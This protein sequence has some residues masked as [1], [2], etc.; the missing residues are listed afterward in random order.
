MRTSAFTVNFR[1]TSWQ[2]TEHFQNANTGHGNAEYLF[3]SML[4]LSNSKEKRHQRFGA[5][6]AKKTVTILLGY[7]Q[8][9]L[10]NFHTKDNTFITNINDQAL[11]GYADAN[12][13]PL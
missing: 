4:I 1:A 6:S 5:F 8:L 11:L 2:P 9:F 13:L 10:E 12:P 7:T 3:L